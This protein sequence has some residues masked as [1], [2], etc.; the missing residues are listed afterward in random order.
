MSRRRNRGCATSP[1][2]MQN[3]VTLSNKST[4]N[5]QYT[6]NTWSMRR[7]NLHCKMSGCNKRMLR[8]IRRSR[9]WIKVLNNESNTKEIGGRFHMSL[10]LC[11][12]RNHLPN[13]VCHRRNVQSKDK[14]KTEDP[15]T[16]LSPA[17]VRFSTPANPTTL[18][19]LVRSSVT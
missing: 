13:W 5:G 10:V 16:S 17:D 19:N 15:Y 14:R 4:N 12:S 6:P 1:E 9:T 2:L 7:G 8:V 18:S 3:R 11:H